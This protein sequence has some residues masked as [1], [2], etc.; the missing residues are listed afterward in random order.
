MANSPARETQP[1]VLVVLNL[2]VANVDSIGLVV[3]QTPGALQIA[4]QQARAKLDRPLAISHP[5]C[6]HRQRL[7]TIWQQVRGRVRGLLARVLIL[8]DPPK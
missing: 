8:T 3:R 2:T 1:R 4:W 7:P 5:R 6:L